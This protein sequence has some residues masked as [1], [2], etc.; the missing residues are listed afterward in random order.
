MAI[1]KEKEDLIA[2]LEVFGLTDET[3]RLYL[4]LLK[5]GPQG[6]MAIVKQLNLG[7]NVAYRLL[8]ELTEK[9]LVSVAN[10]S[11]GKKYS[12]LAPSA[13]E[14]VIA[15]REAETSKMRGTLTG[16]VANLEALAGGE[17]KSRIIHYDGIEGLKQVNWNLTKAK[18]EFRVFELEHLSN[19]LDESFAEKARRIWAERKITS[20]DITN[21]TSI[22]PYTKDLEYLHKYSKYRHIDKKILDIKF[23]MFIYNDVVTLLDYKSDHP[24]SVEIYNQSLSDMQRQLFDVIWS[25]AQEMP[26]DPKS[27]W[28]RVRGCDILPK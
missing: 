18:K 25:Q 7:R 12:A 5:S 1:N 2:K 19:Y 26:F 4:S 22:E 10:K 21:H 23:E 13:F 3:S 8:E 9:Q 6:I 16:L 14:G 28:R 20:Y 11:F 24:Q 27:N 17:A 15:R